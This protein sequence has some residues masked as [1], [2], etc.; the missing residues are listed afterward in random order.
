MLEKFMPSKFKEGF[1]QE[2]VPESIEQ[3]VHGLMVVKSP[4]F[5]FLLLKDL[6]SCLTG[7]SFIDHLYGVG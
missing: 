7:G 2:D 4:N 1:L 5:N 6:A 3:L